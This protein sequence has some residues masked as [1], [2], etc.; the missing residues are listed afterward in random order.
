MLLSE[1]AVAAGTFT[2]LIFVFTALA[3]PTLK[4]VAIVL[5]VVVHTGFPPSYKPEVLHPFI[6]M[7]VQ[8]VHDNGCGISA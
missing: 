2:N 4:S 5:A 8:D 6:L 1:Q 3:P 7:F